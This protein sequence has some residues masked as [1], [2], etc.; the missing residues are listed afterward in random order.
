MSTG[1][2]FKVHDG[3]KPL[4][5]NGP[6]VIFYKEERPKLLLEFP[7]MSF[8]EGAD[9]ISARFRALTP[10]QREKYTKMSQLE[11]ER[12]IRETLEWKNEWENE[13]ERLI[14]LLVHP[15]ARNKDHNYQKGPP[16]LYQSET[17][18]VEDNVSP[19][20]SSVE[21]NICSEPL[22]REK[23]Y[24]WYVE[25]S[26]SRLYD[27]AMKHVVYLQSRKDEI[28]IDRDNFM[29]EP[30]DEEVLEIRGVPSSTIPA[31]QYDTLPQDI[32]TQ[33]KRHQDDMAQEQ[34]IWDEDDDAA[35]ELRRSGFVLPPFSVT[36][37]KH[38]IDEFRGLE[39][40]QI[41]DIAPRCHLHDR[42]LWA[43]GRSDIEV[44]D[45]RAGKRLFCRLGTEPFLYA[46]F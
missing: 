27:A 14:L 19:S 3:E 15:S 24:H 34:E 12:Y 37:S 31:T 25:L 43:R 30:G 16:G 23:V 6:Y 29:V 18:I 46:T 17:Q 35:G 13:I 44:F 4:R 10:T 5:P 20:L 2:W 41:Q 32:Q 22:I 40:Y 38:V 33:I 9:R 8:R 45:A 42:G 1:T 26:Q 36:L 7:N 39:V 28:E 21:L 11:M